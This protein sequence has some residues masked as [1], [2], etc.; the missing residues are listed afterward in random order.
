MENNILQSFRQFV[1]R[2]ADIKD[3]ITSM[4]NH[5]FGND[6]RAEALTEPCILVTND[7]SPSQ[8]SALETEYVKG[9][10]TEVGGKTA[11]SAIIANLLGIPYVVVQDAMTCFSEGQHVLLNG[12]DG[13]VII[14]PDQ[15]QLDIYDNLRK[16]LEI[17]ENQY[18]T[19][20]GKTCETKDQVEVSL[21][22]NI[23]QVSDLEFVEKSEARSIGLFRTEFI[24]MESNHL[25][26][27]QE[28]MDIYKK[29][30]QTMNYGY[31][32]IRTMDIGGDKECAHFDIPKEDNPFLG[33][34]G[35]RLCLEE[36]AIFKTQLRAILRASAFGQ[37]KIM[38]PMIAS[39]DELITAKSMI[40]D[41]MTELENQG[42]DYDK[43]IAVGMM[44][45]TPAAVVMADI[46]AKEVDFFSIGT[47]DL[48]QYTMTVDRANL[49]VAYLYSPYDP[50]ILRSV[51]TI[52][53]AANLEGIPVSI[54]G[55]AGADVLLLPYWIALGIK[56]LSMSVAVLP[57]VK[58]RIRQIDTTDSD[59]IIEKVMKAKS[60]REVK[61]LL[62]VF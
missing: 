6:T 9:I 55:E 20:A 52:A 47:N 25:P 48:I 10:I 29:V 41:C 59:D 7:L 11:H 24:F 38:F 51:K 28:Q 37:I 22:A 43:N 46:L 36:V 3:I 5:V 12:A 50:A 53:D 60:S 27:E 26:T 18:A 19:L 39:Y 17:L 61:A 30:V 35:I 21:L 45:E 33:Y 14:D 4:I 56:K 34:R 40:T 23:G 13:Q 15:E 8:T 31:V 42:I 54:C 62:C 57:E 2:A 58:W 32:T 1:E 16:K 44:M 49:K